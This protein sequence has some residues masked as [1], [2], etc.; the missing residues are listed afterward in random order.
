MSIREIVAKSTLSK[1]SKPKEVADALNWKMVSP[2]VPGQT[3]EPEPDAPADLTDTETADT[4]LLSY[5]ALFNNGKQPSDKQL[6]ALAGA[7]GVSPQNLEK[8]VNAMLDRIVD[9]DGIDL[10]DA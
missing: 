6:H 10:Q 2:K 3:P 8:Q 7:L 9:S 1:G 5:F 4:L